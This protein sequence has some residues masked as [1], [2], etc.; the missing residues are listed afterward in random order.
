MTELAI[1]DDF[2]KRLLF[3]SIVMI[4]LGSL[5][6]AVMINQFII[7]GLPVALLFGIIFVLRA[8]MGI[9]L[10]LAGITTF[11]ILLTVLNI[12]RPI[13]VYSFLFVS[14][15][16]PT[17]YFILSGRAKLPEKGNPILFAVGFFALIYFFNIFRTSFPQHTIIKTFVLVSSGLLPFIILH[18]FSDDPDYLIRGFKSS[19]YLG[20]IPIMY[21]FAL[22]FLMGQGSI[23]RFAPIEVVNLNIVARTTGLLGLIAVWYFFETS[24]KA[25]KAYLA[26]FI[27]SSFFLIVL[28][29]SRASLLASFGAVVMY[30]VLFS[31]MKLSNRIIAGIAIVAMIA[32][33]MFLGLG[34]MLNRFNN[35]KY[36]DLAVAGRVG[37]WLAAWEHRFDQILIG[38]GTGNFASILP[39]WAVG[40]G[41]RFPHNLLIEFYIE[42]GVFGVI[43]YLLLFISPVVVW[44]KIWRSDDYSKKTKEFANLLITFVVFMFVNGLADVTASDPFLFFALGALSATSYGMARK[45]TSS[46]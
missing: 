23:L 8:E 27:V 9:G 26:I 10:F 29:G 1:K 46:K 34:A 3:L 4:G 19:A 36:M 18:F 12:D 15:T 31:G 45:C 20:M 16:V 7:I 43:S 39:A 17:L 35:L 6:G 37:M 22:F 38:H 21:S 14:M 13:L 41:L 2:L 5:F 33:P 28:T 24:A 32:I 40:N 44:F 25:T 11:G 42:W 30:I